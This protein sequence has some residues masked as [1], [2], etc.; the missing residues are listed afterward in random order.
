MAGY[1][2]MQVK[3]FF[4]LKEKGHHGIGE[5]QFLNN[6]TK[7]G[8]D[9]NSFVVEVG[10]DKINK[11]KDTLHGSIFTLDSETG[12]KFNRFMSPSMKSVKETLGIR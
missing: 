7:C 4:G 5:R 9:P 6:I 2:E 11:A 8:V 1:H 10:M 3:H 12:R